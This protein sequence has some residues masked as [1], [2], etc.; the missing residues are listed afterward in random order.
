ME[1]VLV[2][3]PEGYFPYLGVKVGST[4]HKTIE[5]MLHDIDLKASARKRGATKIYD[6]TYCV[7]RILPKISGILTST[8]MENELDES[9][10]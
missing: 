5:W 8:L 1:N 9:I 7:S 4:Y 3:K 2:I 10:D 6:D